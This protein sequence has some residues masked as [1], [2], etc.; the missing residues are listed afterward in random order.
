MQFLQLSDCQR[1]QL[2]TDGHPLEWAGFG[3]EVAAM[4]DR[5]ASPGKREGACFQKGL[6][7]AL[8]LHRCGEKISYFPKAV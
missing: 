6:M 7:C 2:Y 3:G 8:R 1:E 4:Q 5:F